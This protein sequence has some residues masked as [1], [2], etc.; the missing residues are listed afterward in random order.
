MSAVWIRFGAELRN[1]WRSWLVLAV[2]AGLAGGVVIAAAA[3][4]RRTETAY[5]RFLAATRAADVIMTNGTAY[6]NLN[7]QFDFETV[8]RLPQVAEAVKFGYYVVSG[9]ARGGEINPVNSSFFASPDGRFGGDLNRFVPLEGRHAQAEDEV[10][11]SFLVAERSGIRLGDTVDLNVFGPLALQRAFQEGGEEA[12]GALF[13]GPFRPFRVVGIGALQGAF[14]PNSPSTSV[15]PIALFS[16]AYARTNQ[17]DVEVFAIRLHGGRVD[18][19]AFEQALD[20]MAGGAQVFT[21]T[22]AEGTPL[23]QRGLEVQVTSLRVLAALVALI[24]VLLVAQALARQ[25][26]LEADD[27]PVL[28]AL[29]MTRAQLGG[30][31][32]A[33]AAAMG[34]V[35]AILAVAVAVALSPLAP[36]GVA[37]KAELSPGV[38]LNVAYVGIG[39]AAVV[40]VVWGLGAVPAWWLARLSRG[41]RA[42]TGLAGPERPSRVATALSGAGF[43][44]AAVSG[45]R[46]AL[47][48]GRGT[49]AVPVRST[50]LGAA[51]G[52]ATI[53]AVLTFAAGLDRLLARPALYGWNWD[54]QGGGTFADD[55]GEVAQNLTRDPT[56]SEVSVGTLARLQVGTLRVDTLGLESITGSV[57]PT[58]V[59]GRAPAGP[60]EIFLGTKTLRDLDLDVGDTMPVSFADRTVPMRVVGRGLLNEFAGAARL[61]EGATIT[62]EALRTL[63]PNSVRNL[64]LVRFTPGVEAGPTRAKLTEAL[65]NSGIYFPSRP[66][67]LDSL[68][69]VG[70]MPFVVA[71]LLSAMAMGTLAHTLVSSVRRR[72]RDLAILKTLGFVRREVSVAVAW[73]ATTLAV[74]ALAVGLPV[75]VAAGRLAWTFFAERLGVPAQPATPALA[76]ILLVPAMVVLANAVAAFPARLA[77]RIQP[78]LAL[79]SE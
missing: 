26:F 12:A 77:G 17:D 67:D 66:S 14:P 49:S 68:R 71:A 54:A 33:R 42:Q 3:G 51:L 4:A 20:R 55:Q 62:Y 35:A 32:L 18:V 60:D 75:G 13:A 30:L 8:R 7:S 28:R 56:I 47:E 74:V 78:A 73:Q 58:V 45:V 34:V 23:V 5:P 72:R 48:R 79:R 25:A 53:A 76:A 70:S 10:V 11:V 16:P 57:T 41:E 29:G 43:S 59:E 19:P 64:V 39:T 52:V 15:S 22:E 38:E 46:L 37:R 40:L 2:L 63:V 65:G 31:A 24:A 21:V 1:R 9:G 27:H 69:R 44:P 50:I 36:V 61:G 6:A